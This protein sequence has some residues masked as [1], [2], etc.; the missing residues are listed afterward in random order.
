M[1]L[2]KRAFT[3]RRYFSITE[4]DD[5][6]VPEALTWSANYESEFMNVNPSNRMDDTEEMTGFEEATQDDILTLEG[7]GQHVRRLLPNEAAFFLGSCL[8]KITSAQPD[9]IGAPLV[10]QH[11]IE[12]NLTT[13]KPKAF[14]MVEDNGATKN[15]YQATIARSVQIVGERGNFAKMTVELASM[16]QEEDSVE[17]DPGLITGES[18]L[19]FGDIEFQ[20]GG[21]LSGSV[22]AGTL[23]V[24]GG[25]S[26]KSELRSFEASV[27]N[28][29]EAIHEFG[30]A[31]GFVTRFEFADRKEHTLTAELEFQDDGH[32]DA[33]R[34][35]TEY[36]LNIPII[37]ATIETTFKYT[38]NLFYPKVVYEEV[39]KSRDGNKLIVSANFKVLE[40]T[41]FGSIIVE[42]MNKQ[43]AYLT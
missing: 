43:T 26:F 28:G 24:A 1:P 16:G 36:V 37:G 20:R 38:I 30:D 7:G 13:P 42:I 5:F 31:S 21:A 40:D 12:R 6:N 11:Y 32:A 15:R 41:T 9:N 33:L 4:Q 2:T 19:R 8:G 29:A 18:Y 3:G 17:A 22:A 34:N 25:T 35:G 23:A 39:S 27:N 14:T 10:W